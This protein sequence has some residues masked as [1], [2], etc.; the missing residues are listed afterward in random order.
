M[1]NIIGLLDTYRLALLDD[2]DYLG[3]LAF[4]LR[5]RSASTEELANDTGKPK[6]KVAV[7]VRDLYRA[8]WISISS[9]DRL[10]LRSDRE[11]FLDELGLFDIALDS[12]LRELTQS[13]D[14]KLGFWKTLCELRSRSDRSR[15]LHSLQAA[16]WTAQ[17]L[18]EVDHSVRLRALRLLV[19]EACP[20]RTD[21]WLTSSHG[22]DPAEV[23]R[24]NLWVF[25]RDS[26][27]PSDATSRDVTIRGVLLLVVFWSCY[28][29][30]SDMKRSAAQS[31]P[32]RLALFWSEHAARHHDR[33]DKF[34]S[35]LSRC[36]A[37]FDPPTDKVSIQDLLAKVL[38]R[39]GEPSQET[40]EVDKDASCRLLESAKKEES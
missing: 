26:K 37:E 14:E 25:W 30:D 5:N 23:D 28:R 19:G 20:S 2:P 11:S 21:L 40:S 22:T 9:Q 18:P 17:L 1:K 24:Q 33:G 6:A 7:L 27:L 13:E 36:L 16:R 3:I 15:C 32:D 29:W 4:L 12:L 8:G 10:F 34:A 35:V 39:I 38:R 31:D